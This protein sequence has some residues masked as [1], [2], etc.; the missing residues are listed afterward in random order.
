MKIITIDITNDEE[1]LNH[2][3]NFR[4]SSKSNPVIKYIS[5]PYLLNIEIEDFMKDAIP[6]CSLFSNK[7]IVLS[8]Y[9]LF[10]N[11]FFA[12]SLK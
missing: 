3:D 6:L 7:P 4:S 8:I 9:V 11:L 1:N 2:A 12:V 10:I 5:A